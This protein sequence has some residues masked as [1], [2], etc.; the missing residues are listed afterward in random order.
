MRFGEPPRGIAV[1]FAGLALVPVAYG[2]SHLGE[3]IERAVNPAI[4][5][6]YQPA[7]GVNGGTPTYFDRNL[8]VVPVPSNRGAAVLDPREPLMKVSENFTFIKDLGDVPC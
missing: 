6:D 2:V 1:G 4:V 3:Q 8:A 5:I 7:R